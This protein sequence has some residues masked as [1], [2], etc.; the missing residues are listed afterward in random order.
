[1]TSVQTPEAEPEQQKQPADAAPAKPQKSPG[2]DGASAPISPAQR[3]QIIQEHLKEQQQNAP[4]APE[5]DDHADI[6]HSIWNISYEHVRGPMRKLLGVGAF[7]LNPVV[8]VSVLAGDAVLRNTVGKLPVVGNL[9]N[10]P[11]DA[12]VGAA[13]KASDFI[14]GTV[15]APT[16]SIDVVENVYEGISGTV[17]REAHGPVARSVEWS[18]EK[19]G[20]ILGGGIN[21]LK[22]TGKKLAEVPWQKG[23]EN[24]GHIVA[25]PITLPVRIFKGA[26]DTLK[27]FTGGVAGGVIGLGLGAGAAYLGYLG[28]AQYAWPLLPTGVQQ[29]LEQAALHVGHLFK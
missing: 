15:T 14:A 16:A 26:S 19:V 7:A 2:G 3:Q 10:A 8:G 5:H 12:V 22:W 27:P 17:R 9:Y 18:T 13:T 23:A 28:A 21:A 1:M 11:R 20:Q 6:P 29:A 25:A 24:I 4:K